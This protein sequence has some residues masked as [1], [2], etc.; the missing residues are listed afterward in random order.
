MKP[1]SMEQMRKML[2]AVS[3]DMLHMAQAQKMIFGTPNSSESLFNKFAF[4]SYGHIP[5]TFYIPQRNPLSSEAQMINE[6]LL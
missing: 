3:N 2:E 1:V 4:D 5:E 6:G